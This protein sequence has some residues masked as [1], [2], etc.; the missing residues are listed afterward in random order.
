MAK[1]LNLDEFS[2]PMKVVPTKSPPHMQV[3]NAKARQE[4]A[5]RNAK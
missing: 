5:R 1:V 4:E 3:E 2:R